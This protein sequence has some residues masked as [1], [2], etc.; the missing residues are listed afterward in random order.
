M[1]ADGGLNEFPA[2]AFDSQSG[3]TMGDP[4]RRRDLY[5]SSVYP[6]PRYVVMVIDHGSALS[7][8]QLNIAKAIG[9]S[10]IDH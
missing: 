3:H 6:E 8:N 7:R 2:H 1:G 10:N 4:V 9:N 5:F